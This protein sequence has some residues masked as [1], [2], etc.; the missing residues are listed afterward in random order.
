MIREYVAACWTTVEIPMSETPKKIEFIMINDSAAELVMA[1][2]VA[3]MDSEDSTPFFLMISIDGLIYPCVA[4]EIPKKQYMI[5]TADRNEALDFRLLIL[6]VTYRR[7]RRSS[8][9]SRFDSQ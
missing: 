7:G 4:S 9:P 2:K 1:S 3:F 5:P 8:R 6:S